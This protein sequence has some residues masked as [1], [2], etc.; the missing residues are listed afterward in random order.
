MDRQTDRRT[1]RQKT[2]LNAKNAESY[3]KGADWVGYEN[4]ADNHHDGKTDR[5]TDRQ[6]THLNA[7][8]A[9]SYPK[10]AY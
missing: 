2:H 9:E 5:R 10:G 1:D 3:P 6:I 8:N 4:K 7:K